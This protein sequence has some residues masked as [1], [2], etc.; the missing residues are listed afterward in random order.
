MNGLFLESF[1]TKFGWG[2]KV[3]T[4]HG[5]QKLFTKR[6]PPR[7][8]SGTPITFEATK[9][10][11]GNS[12]Y[13]SNIHIQ[14]RSSQGQRQAAA[15]SLPPAQDENNKERMIFITG[16]TGRA[17]QSGQFGLADVKALALAAAEAFDALSGEKAPSPEQHGYG[18]DLPFND[19][20][21]DIPGA[22]G[23]D[24]YGNFDPNEPPF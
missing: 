10:Q 2:V 12:W 11:Q 19:P 6:E 16:V 4:Q 9:A 3:R 23:Q 13:I 8:V 15:P 20:I 18:Q 24:D 21:G 14:G 7:L 17:M 1:Q 22:Q 5:E